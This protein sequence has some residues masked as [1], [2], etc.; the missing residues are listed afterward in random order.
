M[1]YT[2]AVPD[3]VGRPLDW[4]A[5]ALCRSKDPELFFDGSRETE[6]KE[7]CHAC[8]V[9]ADCRNLVMDTERGWNLY[10]RAGIVAELTPSERVAADPAVPKPPLELAATPAQPEREH[11][12]RSTYKA[13]C[14]C[15]SCTAANR[16]YGQARKLPKSPDMPEPAKGR[17]VTPCPSVAAYKR[18]VKAG[19][20]IDAGCRQ[21][22]A[23][24]RAALRYGERDRSVYRLW[25][26]G[27]SDPEIAERL[28]VG[29]RAVRNARKRIGLIPDLHV[30]RAS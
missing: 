26:K 17:R 21:A 14:R 20:P 18:H 22:Y 19:E 5:D 13:G 30:R 4:Q 24:H 10:L 23:R 28:S 27:L 7:V 1:S 16:E 9:L 29:V 3:T 2:G 11:G 15:E 25:V 6:A 8:P 12:K